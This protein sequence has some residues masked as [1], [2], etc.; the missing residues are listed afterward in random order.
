MNYYDLTP[1]IDETTPVW[2]GDASLT[3]NRILD[4]S[5]GDNVNLSSVTSTVHIGSH[6]DAPS[7]FSE[8]APGIDGINPLVYIGHCQVIEVDAVKAQPMEP[9]MLN[10]TIDSTRILLKTGTG[11]T[12][13]LSEDFAYLSAALVDAIAERGVQLVGMDTPSVDAFDS[14]ELPMHHACLAHNIHILEGLC[15][16]GVPAGCYFLSAIPLRLAGFD[17][18]PVRAILLHLEDVPSLVS[19]G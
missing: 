8:N 7:H 15:L 14:A 16:N 13:R 12:A 2:P 10:A 18:S 9:H 5:R 19:R 4:L 6:A 11:D 1:P 17:A 3:R